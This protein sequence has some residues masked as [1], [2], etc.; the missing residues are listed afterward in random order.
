[1]NSTKS[2]AHSD[3]NG[4][5]EKED[6]HLPST[7]SSSLSLPHPVQKLPSFAIYHDVTLAS[8]VFSFMA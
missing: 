7:Q 6:L 1:V 4:Q 2:T 3:E 5:V 8:E